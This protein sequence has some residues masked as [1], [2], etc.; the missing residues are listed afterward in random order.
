M[1]KAL[2]YPEINIT[3]N[4]IAGVLDI[5]ALVGFISLKKLLPNYI[6][7]YLSNVLLYLSI[8]FPIGL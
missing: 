5:Q 7:K 6:K 4:V 8:S 1:D 2:E 3:D